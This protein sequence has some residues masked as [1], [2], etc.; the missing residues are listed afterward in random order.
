MVRKFK[1][2]TISITADIYSR[3]Y[4]IQLRFGASAWPSIYYVY[5][6]SFLIKRLAIQCGL[7]NHSVLQI[8]HPYYTNNKKT[9][10]QNKELIWETF[11]AQLHVSRQRFS[12]N[13]WPF[14]T[15]ISSLVCGG[16]VSEMIRARRN[17]IYIYIYLFRRN[18]FGRNRRTIT[19]RWHW[20][21]FTSVN[22]WLRKG[23]VRR[24][25]RWLL[26]IAN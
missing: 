26:S 11:C 19:P 16:W 14:E 3:I 5:S 23:S 6:S 20:I 17:L 7:S 4:I 21:L 13:L 22:G 2:H 12:M 24:I 25:A 1:T 18:L 15:R 8:I 10:T 9:H